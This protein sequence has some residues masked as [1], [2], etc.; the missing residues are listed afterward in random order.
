[1][2]TLIVV[3]SH[4]GNT[5]RVAEAMAK[6]LCSLGSCEVVDVIN[7]PSSVPADIDLLLVGGPTE[8]HGMTPEMRGYLDGLCASVVRGKAVAAFDT[9][10][11]WPKILSGSAADGIAR[12]LVELDGRLVGQPASFIVST[13]PE[14]VPGEI[15]RAQRWADTIAARAMAGA[16]PV[17]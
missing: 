15:E 9:R 2:H 17:A 14:L 16:A 10:L 6:R 7:G 13:A 1:M 3:N 12:K 11:A 4:Q 5:R 8:G